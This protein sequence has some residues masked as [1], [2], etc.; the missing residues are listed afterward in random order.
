MIFFSITYVP[1]YTWKTAICLFVGRSSSLAC[2]VSSGDVCGT[3]HPTVK[4]WLLYHNLGFKN[5]LRKVSRGNNSKNHQ[6]I[7]I[8]EIILVSSGKH[9]IYSEAS[10]KWTSFSLYGCWFLFWRYHDVTI[11]YKTTGEWDEY[12][13][14]NEHIPSQDTFEDDFPFLKVGYVLFPAVYIILPNDFEIQ[15]LPIWQ[16]NF[17]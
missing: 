11:S 12:P 14:W 4:V 9:R 5:H 6:C 16:E 1:L 17:T 10:C 8:W 15:H 7:I 3:G 13:S 2:R